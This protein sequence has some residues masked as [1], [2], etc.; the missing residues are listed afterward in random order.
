MTL[1]NF[2]FDK[3]SNSN[4]IK[5][6]DFQRNKVIK[7]KLGSNVFTKQKLIAKILDKNCQFYSYDNS[8]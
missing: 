4:N 2:N 5:Y 1:V 8:K 3:K 6:L 7:S